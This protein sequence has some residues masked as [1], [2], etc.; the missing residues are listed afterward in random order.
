ISLDM[1]TFNVDGQQYV[2]WAQR[3]DASAIYIA[4]VD[5]E[6]PWKLTSDVTLICLPD[7]SWE[8]NDRTPVDEGPFAIITDDKVFITYSGSSTGTPYCVGLLSI[9]RDADFLDAGNWHKSNYPIVDSNSVEGECGVG[10]NSYTTDADGNLVFVY[11]ARNRA[12]NTG[13][14]SGLRTVQFDAD[15]EPVLYLTDVMELNPEFEV[16]STKLVIG[17]KPAEPEPTANP[18]N[19]PAPAGNSGDKTGQP[20]QTGNGNNTADSYKTGD[21]VKAGGYNYRITSDTTVA[22]TGAA[23]KSVKSINIK[24]TVEIGGKTY[25]VTEVAAGAFKGYKKAAKA[26]IGKNIKKIGK[27]AFFGCSSLK[28]ITVKSTGI[29]SVG[30]NAFKKLAK[31]CKATYPKSKKAS[32]K[33]LFKL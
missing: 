12:N 9:D 29:K 10:H 21:K 8:N 28:K 30:K 2:A 32:Y 33:K 26:L 4:T 11:H 5:E 13:R 14:L 22:V 17:D 27:K 18:S 7:Y 6:E 15:G 3:N 20:S 16:V 1:T 25:K 31:K 24:A 19:T 23:S